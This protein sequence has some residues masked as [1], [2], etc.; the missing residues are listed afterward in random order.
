[1]KEGVDRIPLSRVIKASNHKGVDNEAFSS[2][3][4]KEQ[5]D[6][7]LL[8]KKLQESFNSERKRARLTTHKKPAGLTMAT[9]SQ[10]HRELQ[11]EELP[12]DVRQSVKQSLDK[13]EV[14]K[15]AKQKRIERLILY[16]TRKFRLIIKPYGRQRVVE[17]IPRDP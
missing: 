14:Y 4:G 2:F 15:G 13:I 10:N 11:V 7:I 6:R 8:S 12:F 5:K 9:C 17:L 1:M 3:T 16:E